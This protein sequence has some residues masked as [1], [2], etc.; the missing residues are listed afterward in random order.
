M[1]LIDGIGE[2]KTGRHLNLLKVKD[3]DRY[4]NIALTESHCKY[5][6]YEYKIKRSRA[7]FDILLNSPLVSLP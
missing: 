5:P 3:T 2:L 1:H 6:Q 7:V 4:S